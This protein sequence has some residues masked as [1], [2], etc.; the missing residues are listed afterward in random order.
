LPEI[1]LESTF[2]LL[3]QYY[4]E[5]GS[6]TYN[7]IYTSLPVLIMGIYD[8]DLDAETALRHP[9]LY[10]F[11][12]S[13]SSLS[14]RVFLSVIFGALAETLAVFFVCLNGYYLPSVQPQTPYVFQQG[15]VTLTAVIAVVSL[16]IAAETHSHYWFFSGIVLVSCILWIPACYLFD[17][18]NQNYLN[19]GMRF[20]FG[21]LQAYLT[22][23]LCMGIAGA[24]IIAWKGYKRLFHPELRHLIQETVRFGL[25]EAQIDEYSD[26]ADVARRTGKSIPEVFDALRQLDNDS[27]RSNPLSRASA[28]APSAH[29]AAMGSQQTG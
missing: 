28:G 8:R 23:L 16:R 14:L 5:Y 11:T 7:L 17:A 25:D 29:S 27:K 4:V 20:V 18:L 22:I 24:R 21:S 1:D 26:V 6:Q 3:V 13:G 2:S 12:R 10:D 15:T 19:G 9:T